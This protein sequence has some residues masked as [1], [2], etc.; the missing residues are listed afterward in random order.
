VNQRA[1]LFLRPA[2]VV[3]KLKESVG[4]V[5]SLAAKEPD[6]YNAGAGGWA[7]VRRPTEGTLPMDV[8]ERWIGESYRLMAAVP[9]AKKPPAK[10]KAA[11]KGIT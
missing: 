10:K 1:F 11:R 3:L 5:E 9:A 2:S 7:T 6:L 8:M 4:D